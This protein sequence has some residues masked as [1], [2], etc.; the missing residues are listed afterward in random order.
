M[1]GEEAVKKREIWSNL[2][3]LLT[4]GSSSLADIEKRIHH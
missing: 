3:N 1:V 2:G 4:K